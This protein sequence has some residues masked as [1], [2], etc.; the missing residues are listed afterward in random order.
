[1]IRQQRQSYTDEELYALLHPWVRAWFRGQFETF[2]PPQRYAIPNV[3][4]RRNCLIS[5]PT[6][7][8]KTLSAFLAILSEL[9]TLA[10]RGELDNRIYCVYVSPLKAL[11]NDIRRNLEEPLRGIAQ[12]AGKELGI[13]VA[14]R[15]GDTS[16]HEKQKMLHRAPHILITTPESLAIALTAR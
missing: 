9:V 6:G 7:S 1:M 14:V 4:D 16:A 10:E 11:G 3:H 5:A 8:G 15:T 13:R 2:S 12:I